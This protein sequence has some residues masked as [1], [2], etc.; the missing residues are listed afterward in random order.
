METDKALT[1]V[2]AP[3]DGVVR[4]IEVGVGDTVPVGATLVLLTG[5]GDRGGR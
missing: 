1:D 3:H 5:A 4:A 2:V